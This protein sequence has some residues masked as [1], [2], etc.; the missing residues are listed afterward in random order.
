[1]R[2]VRE[3]PQTKGLL[4]AGTE[5]GVYV[6][7]DDGDHWQSLQLN[8]PVTSVRDLTIHG[9]DLVIATHGRSFWILDDIT[10]LRQTPD[11]GKASRAWL[12]HPAT[13]T[14]IDNDTF[15][16]TPLPPEEPTAENPPSGCSDRLLPEI[17]FQQRDSRDFRRTA[18]SGTEVLF[19]RSEPNQARAA[20]R[21]G[22]LVSQARYSGE[23]SWNAPFRLEPHVGKFWRTDRRRRHRSSQSQ[24]TE[25]DTGNLSGPPYGRRAVPDSIARCHH[26]PAVT[27]D[28]RGSGAAVPTRSTDI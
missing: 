4:F 7:F 6:S 25:S 16:G 22:A 23:D 27:R 14:R 19:R 11:S 12:F 13:S 20:S 1:M 2:A 8:L 24:R 15:V 18:E 28:C 9:D 3:D 17:R 26:G 5:S 10:P 21:G